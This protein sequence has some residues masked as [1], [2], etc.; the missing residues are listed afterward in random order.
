MTCKSPGRGGALRQIAGRSAFTLLELLVVVAI[1]G[2]LAVL[3]FPAVRSGLDSA[4]T[5]GCLAN[6]KQIGAGLAL[7]GADQG[8]TTPLEYYYGPSPEAVGQ[9]VWWYWADLIQP[10]TDPAK[11]RPKSG[12]AGNSILERA[13][14]STV[15]D[16]PANRLDIFDYKYNQRTGN[17]NISRGMQNNSFSAV[18]SVING[19]QGV[20]G[21]R[22]DAVVVL[23][24]SAPPPSQFILVM[25]SVDPEYPGMANF[26]SSFI[27]TRYIAMHGEGRRF[28]AAYADGHSSSLSS[29][30]LATY[31]NGLPFDLPPGS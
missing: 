10:Y 23:N 7:F 27:R 13:N 1:I 12:G 17:F 19:V 25:D 16:C 3:L 21:V 8:G 26:N 15:Y 11:P 28:N 18:E 22:L 20:F 9:N 5:A 6:M 2:I 14:R 24:R 29:N 30:V 31:T 4:R